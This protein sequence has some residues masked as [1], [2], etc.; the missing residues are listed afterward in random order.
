MESRRNSSLSGEHSYVLNTL[1]QRPERHSDDEHSRLS[2]T[3]FTEPNHRP[4]DWGA[5]DQRKSRYPPSPSNSIPRPPFRSSSVVIGSRNISTHRLSEQVSDSRRNSSLVRDQSQRLGSHRNSRPDIPDTSREAYFSQSGNSTERSPSERKSVCWKD[6]HE[7]RD[8][9]YGRD[10]ERDGDKR[11]DIKKYKDRRCDSE[12]SRIRDRE[13]RERGRDSNR[14]DRD[15]ESDRDEEYSLVPSSSSR[16]KRSSTD[17]TPRTGHLS[18]RKSEV[19]VKNKGSDNHGPTFNDI[20]SGGPGLRNL[21]R[22][23]TMDAIET[24]TN[25][26]R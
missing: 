1:A 3:N 13:R 12:Y 9:H 24:L 14:R 20:P 19:V 6:K 8:R 5:L 21:L 17:Y 26:S 7:D 25:S 23:M 16:R 2:P 15:R 4:R 10:S 18:R 11:R 22:S